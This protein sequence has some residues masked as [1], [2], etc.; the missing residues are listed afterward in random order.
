MT[1]K[2]ADADRHGQAKGS[3]S[4][5]PGGKGERRWIPARALASL[6]MLQAGGHCGRVGHSQ[7]DK[8]WTELVGLV[9]DAL[10]LMEVGGLRKL[11]V[12]TKHRDTFD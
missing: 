5:L 4:R 9:T 7:V 11:I 6:V 1:G 12:F 3:G 8:K 2:V 10:G